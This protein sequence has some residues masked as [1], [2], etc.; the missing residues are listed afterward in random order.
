MTDEEY[1]QLSL[2]GRPE[3]FRFLVTRYETALIRHLAGRLGNRDDAAEA[4][5]E[6]MV[7]AYFALSKLKKAESF[8]PWLLGIADRVAQEMRRAHRRRPVSLDFDVVSTRAPADAAARDSCTDPVLS[9]AVAD[10]PEPYRQVIVMRFYGGHSCAEIGHMLGL[11][12]GTV[13]SRLSRAYGTLR[14]ALRVH[15]QNTQPSKLFRR[16]TH[17]LFAV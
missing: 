13:T 10:L 7:R 16:T 3:M 5:Q 12:L 2:G 4:A 15:D 14:Q 1:V 11:S 6:A 9:Q 17:D 8:F